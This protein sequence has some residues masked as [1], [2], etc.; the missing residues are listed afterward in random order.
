MLEYVSD[1]PARGWLHTHG[2]ARHGKPELE[3][4]HV[5]MFLRTPACSLLNRVADY[6]LN[7]ATAPLLP[8][9]TMLLGNEAIL[10]VASRPDEDAGYDSLHYDGCVRLCLVDPPPGSCD[11]D[12]CAKEL[13]RRSSLPS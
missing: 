8:G 13:A 1:G 3:L 6:L 12:E 10:L 2:L 11:C 9:Q 5:P 4:R 7:D